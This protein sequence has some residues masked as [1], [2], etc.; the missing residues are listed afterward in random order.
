M[1]LVIEKIGQMRL[2]DNLTN[3]ENMTHFAMGKVK[4]LKG[5]GIIMLEN[6][7]EKEVKLNILAIWSPKDIP[8]TF[9]DYYEVIK[10]PIE[11][12]NEETIDALVYSGIV[13]IANSFF[14]KA[15]TM[16]AL[17][18][19]GKYPPIA[20]TIIYLENIDLCKYYIN[21]QEDATIATTQHLN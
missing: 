19:I 11:E 15:W 12:S 18:K 2:L 20:I 8:I 17:G 13:N 14:E 6:N 21:T 5:T 16:I 3:I 7:E 4:T 1:E 10:K 9:N